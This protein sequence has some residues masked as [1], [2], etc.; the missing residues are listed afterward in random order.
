M[1]ALRFVGRGM[2]ISDRGDTPKQ[3]QCLDKGVAVGKPIDKNGKV[4]KK[5]TER[6]SIG[7]GRSYDNDCQRDEDWFFDNN[8][9]G[10]RTDSSCPS[11]SEAMIPKADFSSSPDGLSPFLRGRI[12]SAGSLT[13]SGEGDREGVTTPIREGLDIDPKVAKDNPTRL[14]LL[15]AML[16]KRRRESLERINTHTHANARDIPSPECTSDDADSART[17]RSATTSSAV[18]SRKTIAMD[19]TQSTRLRSGSNHRND[20]CA[21]ERNAASPVRG[22]SL[23]RSD[24]SL[25]RF[26]QFSENNSGD[27]K[28]FTTAEGSSIEFM[29][30]S[31][32]QV[33]EEDSL[34]S[35]GSLYIPTGV[36]N[37]GKVVRQIVIA[38]DCSSGSTRSSS[39]E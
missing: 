39:N 35:D 3:P 27:Q 7:S 28:G 23:S 33:V 29:R 9:R 18:I 38:K 36:P 31:G 37:S 25:R 15:S 10:S 12:D 26:K 11:T 2:S 1:E 30:A 34:N 5:T 6:L 20:G 16:K 32:S 13:P 24:L 22:R 21:A 14:S 4:T 8:G 17:H 19:R